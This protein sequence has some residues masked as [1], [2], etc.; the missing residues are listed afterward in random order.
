MPIGGGWGDQR[1][2]AHTWEGS[3]G[4]RRL[5]AKVRGREKEITRATNSKFF[6]PVSI[7]TEGR[8][9]EM[10][11][12]HLEFCNPKLNFFKVYLFLIERGRV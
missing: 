12:K 9:A 2:R 8:T 6:P 5:K 11:G 3:S 10:A 1:Q 7:M 4:E